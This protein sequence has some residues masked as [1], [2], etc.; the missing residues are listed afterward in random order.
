MRGLI[1]AC[2][3]PSKIESIRHTLLSN[4]QSLIDTRELPQQFSKTQFQKLLGQETQGIIFDARDSFDSNLFTGLNGSL[5]GGGIM[6]IDLPPITMHFL[7]S[8]LPAQLHSSTE[9][10]LEKNSAALI[11]SLPIEALL[12]RF[13]KFATTRKSAAIIVD[14]KTYFFPPLSQQTPSVDLA[15]KEQQAIVGQM[16][17]VAMGHAKRPLV[18]TAPRGR[19]KSSALGL[20]ATRLIAEPNKTI[21]ITAPSLSNLNSFYQHLKMPANTHVSH[22]TK[23]NVVCSNGSSVVFMPVD[24]IIQQPPQANLLIVDE[25]AAIPVQQL[26]LLARQYNRIIFS[27]TSEGYEGNGKGFEVRFKEKLLK[28]MP[29]TRFAALNLPIRWSSEDQLEKIIYS[30]FLLAYP[31]KACRF[32][33]SYSQTHI[34]ELTKKLLNEDDYTLAQV[35]S[36][37]VNAHYQTRP[38]DLERLLSDPRLAVY[39]LCSSDNGADQKTANND[40]NSSHIIGVCLVRT[41]GELSDE[42]IDKLYQGKRESKGELLPQSIVLN[43]GVTSLA[44]RKI[45]RVMR[46]AI[47][48]EM[49]NQGFGSLFL[50]KLETCLSADQFELIGASFAVDDKVLGFWIKNHYALFRFGNAKESSSGSFTSEVLKPLQ[51]GRETKLVTDFE[52]LQSKF[53]DSFLFKVSRQLKSLETKVVYLTLKTIALSL[54]KNKAISESFDLSEIKRFINKQSHLSNVDFQIARWYLSWLIENH[55]LTFKKDRDGLI[56]ELIFKGLDWHDIR[57]SQ[58]LTGKKQIIST[59]RDELKIMLTKLN[60]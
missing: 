33:A 26:D 4:E 58:S 12:K 55:Q 24:Q 57:L 1:L 44:R 19:G 37:L 35:F 53:V 8:L 47:I 17:R 56:I 41:E 49:Q 40:S 30:T 60:E 3:S 7:K 52:S 50:E 9:M 34:K 22:T 13:L 27:T 29:Q 38:N 15:I 2:V 32:N 36:L 59:I 31:V 18:L 45:A 11:Q 14:D 48:P 6:I 5:V 28:I 25:A 23:N 43:Y 16:C 21:L 10:N 51:T 54:G 20:A 42:S 46:I 39:G